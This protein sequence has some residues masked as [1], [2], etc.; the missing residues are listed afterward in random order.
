MDLE[1]LKLHSGSHIPVS[2]LDLLYI[3]T[4]SYK[5]KKTGSFML[6]WST[7]CYF[8]LIKLPGELPLLVYID[9]P[10]SF[11][12]M[13][14]I[15]YYQPGL[16]RPFSIDGQLGCFHVSLLQWTLL[17][18]VL[19]F[20]YFIS[21]FLSFFFFNPH[22]SWLAGLSRAFQIVLHFLKI[23]LKSIGMTRPGIEGLSRLLSKQGLLR[24]KAVVSV[25]IL[26]Q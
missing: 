16:I 8:S 1:N 4:H 3:Y 12:L 11:K 7:V 25:A 13:Q 17:F 14:N 5:E 2:V 15:P 19:F 6:Q 18:F 22:I 24:V 23:L 21:L 9:P 10:F 26:G 20:F